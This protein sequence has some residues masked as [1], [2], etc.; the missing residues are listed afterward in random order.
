MRTLDADMADARPGR[1]RGHRRRACSRR[2]RRGGRSLD[3]D[4]G[5]RGV[6]T[7]DGR[8]AGRPRR[9]GDRASAPDVASPRTAGLTLGETGALRV[10]DHQRC[11][12]P[13]A[14]TPPAT[15]SRATTACSTRP[16]NIQLGTHANKQGRIAGVNATGGD[17][18]FPGV[19]GTAVSQRLQARGRAHRA[20]RARG[21]RGGHRRRRRER[22]G[23][24]AR[25]LLPGRRAD[26]GQA[27]RRAR[28]RAAA[29][30]ADR[31]RRGR[32]EAHRRARDRVWAGHGGR[33]A[34]SWL[35]LAYAPPYSR[36]STRCSSPRA[37]RRA[38]SAA[39]A[40][41]SSRG[42]SSATSSPP[43]PRSRIPATPPFLISTRAP[44]RS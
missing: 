15:A 20:H 32:G 24:L 42:R 13:T 25:R 18:A 39:R 11:P 23:R 10:D 34:G 1:R 41:S 27:R 12:A 28:Q 36:V 37:S 21:R 16:V 35:D 17:L 4:G 9:D 7:S 6:R 33:R 8:A 26:L 38:G 43:P 31:R 29:R 2:E 14:C 44:V 19:V 3:G 5:P 40:R 30:R 22:R